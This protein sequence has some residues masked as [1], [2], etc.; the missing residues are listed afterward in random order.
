[1]AAIRDLPKLNSSCTTVLIVR[2][3]LAALLRID[4]GV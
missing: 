4:P 2:Y 1:M 3:R